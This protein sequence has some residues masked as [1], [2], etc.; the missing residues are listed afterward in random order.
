M[1]KTILMTACMLF[2]SSMAFAGKSV[3]M[4]LSA[5]STTGLSLYGDSATASD[6]TALIGKNSTGVGVGVLTDVNGYS[7]VTQHMNGSKAFA[8]SYDSTSIYSED[9]TAGE[10]LLDVPKATDTSDFSDWDKL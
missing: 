8:S 3:T 9:A 6:T 7:M 1:K 4:D 2:V 10:E 5:K